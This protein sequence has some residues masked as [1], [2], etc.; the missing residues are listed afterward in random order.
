MDRRLRGDQDSNQSQGAQRHP[1]ETD[2]LP[3]EREGVFRKLQPHR[4]GNSRDLPRLQ[5]RQGENRPQEEK[6]RRKGGK[7]GIA[8]LGQKLQS[9]PSRGVTR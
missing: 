1:Q 7:S 3:V 6:T 9:H 5:R 8:K 2:L 4:R